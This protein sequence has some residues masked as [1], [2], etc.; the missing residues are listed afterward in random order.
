[1]DIRGFI[2]N[3]NGTVYAVSAINFILNNIVEKYNKIE[4][5]KASKEKEVQNIFHIFL[6]MVEL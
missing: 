5:K 2:C 6:L 3:E 1:M 4:E